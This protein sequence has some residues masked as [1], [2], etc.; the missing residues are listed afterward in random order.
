LLLFDDGAAVSGEARALID[1]QTL[2]R[3]YGCPV[4]ELGPA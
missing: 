4:G 2:E 3:L 1:R